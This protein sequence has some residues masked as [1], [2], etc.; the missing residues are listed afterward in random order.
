MRAPIYIAVVI[1]FLFL[2]MPL[3]A[4]EKCEHCGK[5]LPLWLDPKKHG[6]AYSYDDALRERSR[7]LDWHKQGTC[8]SEKSPPAGF[9]PGAFPDLPRIVDEDG[10]CIYCG[11]PMPV[12][13][14]ILT[15]RLLR[16]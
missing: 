5:D 14:A 13:I 2:P 16:K 11:G 7:V 6:S 9:E 4:A 10:K 3:L 15:S 8:L 12:H 1:P